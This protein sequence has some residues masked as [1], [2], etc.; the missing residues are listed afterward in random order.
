MKLQ[1]LRDHLQT[2]GGKYCGKDAV[3]C[4]SGME[5]SFCSLGKKVVVRGTRCYL[6]CVIG[7]WIGQGYFFLEEVC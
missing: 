4:R 5:L 1:R 2:T 7:Q 6:Y 3:Q